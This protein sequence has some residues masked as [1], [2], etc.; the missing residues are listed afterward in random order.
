M[1]IIC[2][3]EDN[4]SLIGNDWPLSC[5]ENLL[6]NINNCYWLFGIDGSVSH[7]TFD[8]IKNNGKIGSAQG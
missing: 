3:L 4:P 7:T 5:L 1:T 2:S 8:N 6:D